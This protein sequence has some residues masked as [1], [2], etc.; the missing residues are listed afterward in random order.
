[1][2][3]FSVFQ[4]SFDGG[5]RSHQ[6]RRGR[7]AATALIS[8]AIAV[9]GG[10][11]LAILHLNS[12]QLSDMANAGS[13]RDVRLAGTITTED[14]SC[15]E[16]SWPFIEGRCLIDTRS[17]RK[18]ERALPRQATAKRLSELQDAALVSRKKKART[19]SPDGATVVAT[20][21]R[22]VQTAA[23][24]TGAAPRHDATSAPVKATNIANA[25]PPET[26]SVATPP[27]AT[28]AASPTPPKTDNA[29]APRRAPD[30]HREARRKERLTREQREARAELRSRRDEQRSASRGNDHAYSS[31]Y[32]GG[33]QRGPFDGG[34]FSTIR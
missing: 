13:P 17:L 23:S 6:R 31:S 33:W 12:N 34:F 7:L 26:P 4:A 3:A 30:Q 9:I 25:T 27:A 15:A 24:T 11:V 2:S 22:A 29:I 10:S 28:P 20:R 32:S 16:Q 18:T 14:K 21:S 1:M 8:G 19:K 5:L